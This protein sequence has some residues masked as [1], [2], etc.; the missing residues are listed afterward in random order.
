MKPSILFQHGLFYEDEHNDTLEIIKK[1]FDVTLITDNDIVLNR[2][3]SIQDYD[4]FRGSIALATKYNQL[5]PW[6]NALKWAPFF[7]NSLINPDYIFLDAKS[8]IQSEKLE[9]PLFIRPVAGDKIFSGNVYTKEKFQTEFNYFAI[10]KNGDPN[11][12]CLV[13]SPVKVEREWRLIFVNK[14]YVSGSQYMVNSEF[15][16]DPSVPDYI[17]DYANR[18]IATSD[19]FIN[20]FEFIIDMAETENGIKLVELNQFE[21]ASFYA[22]DLEKIYHT[23]SKV[24]N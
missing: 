15:C 6:C 7:K 1:Y 23:Y 18:H 2:T 24:L 9:W 4:A 3:F 17:V 22:A 12:I 20:K 11:T 19:F 5:K 16:V 8:I 13:C 21:T 10:N 14:E